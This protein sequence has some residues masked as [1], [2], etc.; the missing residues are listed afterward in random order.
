MN[1]HLSSKSEVLLIVQN[2]SYPFDKRVSKEAISLSRNGYNVFVISPTSIYDSEKRT[3]IDNISVYRYKNYLSD[4][5]FI[6][7][8]LEYFLSLIK[9][10]SLSLYL[11]VSKHIKIIHVANP[12][13]FFWPLAL[14]SKL[15]GVKFIYDQHDLAPEMFNIRFSNKL[16]YKILNYNE[17]LTVLLADSII[18]VNKT[19]KER[20][21]KKF[22][23]PSEK[24]EVAYNGPYENFEPIKSDVLIS[25]FKGKKIILYVGLMTITDSIEIIIE[26]AKKIIIDEK[27]TDCQFILLG[28]GD[29][30]L[31]MEHQANEYGISKNISFIGM[32]DYDKVMEY[33]YL[34]DVCI[35]PDLPNGFNEYL[36]L[37]KILE[38]MKAKKAFVSFNLKE[39]KSMAENS[40]LYADDINDYKNK[41]LY[42]IDCPDE[43][44]KMGEIGYE[45]VMNN[46]LWSHSEKTIL[47]LYKKLL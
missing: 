25:K 43:A 9:I 39:T 7:F 34:A 46:Y 3:N 40:G 44:K 45:I 14:I 8:F 12:P 38:Y 36:T 42:L 18:T 24:C 21:I 27:R 41:L 26:V 10:F 23:V 32:V 29:V 37:I 22:N 5:S 6:G 31:K 35:A 30:R 16:I 2:A 11:I 47:N 19:F 20:L 15:F 1:F 28:D 4:G 13:D 33:L 17:K